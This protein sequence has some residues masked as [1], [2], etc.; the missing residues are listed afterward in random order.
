MM[1]SNLASPMPGMG[2]NPPSQHMGPSLGG[3]AMGQTS[4]TQQQGG[5]GGGSVGPSQG[6]YLNHGGGVGGGASN[7]GSGNQNTSEIVNAAIRALHY[8]A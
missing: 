8:S 4:P 6:G 3:P 1:P 5:G 2:G 7:G